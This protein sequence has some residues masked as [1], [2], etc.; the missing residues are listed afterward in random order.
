MNP[1]NP[2][3]AIDAIDA[4]N[5]MNLKPKGWTLDSRL[6]APDIG[7]MFPYHISHIT[8]HDNPNIIL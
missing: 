1:T 3:H 2:I 6:S 7:L 4:I 5:A 8:F